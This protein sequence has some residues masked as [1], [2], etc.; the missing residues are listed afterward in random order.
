MTQQRWTELM[1]EEHFVEAADVM[2]RLPDVCVPGH[3]NTWPRMLYEFSD[4]VNQEPPRMTRVRPNAAAISRMEETLGWLKWL[5]PTDRKV[6]W[7]RAS[8]ARWK[9]VCWKVGLQ[10]AAAHEHWL[11]ALCVVTWK[12]NGQRLPKEL[13]KRRLIERTRA[14]VSA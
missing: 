6:V 3:F 12:L 2:K 4:L 14:A 10:R 7:L 5:E 13:S 1:V 9:T 8:G 11:Y